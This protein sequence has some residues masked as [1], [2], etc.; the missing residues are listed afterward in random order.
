[1]MPALTVN[2]AN[3]PP[4]MSQAPRDAGC[5][6]TDRIRCKP[7]IPGFG[8]LLIALCFHRLWL[9]RFCSGTID[10][11]YDKCTRENSEAHR[12]RNPNSRAGPY[13]GVNGRDARNRGGGYHPDARHREL[14]QRTDRWNRNLRVEPERRPCAIRPADRQQNQRSQ[15]LGELYL[16]FLRWANREPNH[17]GDA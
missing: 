4:S 17:V 1:M 9:W 11:K 14:R 6:G 10:Q 13:R 8:V 2:A 3:A 5:R 15:P 12:E 16:C 7:S